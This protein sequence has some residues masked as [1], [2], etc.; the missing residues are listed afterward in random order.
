MVRDDIEDLTKPV[1]FQRCAQTGMRVSATQCS[2][3]TVM[4][5]N[6]VAVHTSRRGLQIGGAVEMADAQRCQIIN[7]GGS[8]IEAEIS[9]QLHAVGR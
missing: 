7:N 9:M 5:D 2:I 8:G 1:P 4:V 6:I 3:D